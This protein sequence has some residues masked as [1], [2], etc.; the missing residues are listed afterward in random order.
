M[1]LRQWIAALSVLSA[2]VVLPAAL[3]AQI[4][5]TETYDQL[6]IDVEKR[7]PGFGG[8]FIDVDGRLA[9]YLLDVAKLPIARAA[10]EAVFGPARIPAAGVR[11]VQGRYAISQ[12]KTWTERAGALLKLPGVTL[13]DLDEAR[14]RVTIGVEH[15]SRT[16]A[17]A[18][19]LTSLKIPRDVLLIEVSGAIRPVPR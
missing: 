17:V 11:A 18:Q 14:N 2:V 10:I 15:A 8:M 4:A 3:A 9:V 1:K 6:L 7:T 13:V 5:V 12:L 16:S 19:A